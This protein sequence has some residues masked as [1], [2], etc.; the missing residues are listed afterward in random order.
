MAITRRIICEHH[1]E[2]TAQSK[3]NQGTTFRVLLPAHAGE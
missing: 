1:G 3:P 2:I